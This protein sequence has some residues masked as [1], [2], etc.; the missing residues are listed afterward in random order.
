MESDDTDQ[1]VLEKALVA[2]NGLDFIAVKLAVIDRL[3]RDV[4]T[5]RD[6]LRRQVAKLKQQQQV[7]RAT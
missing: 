3:L 1:G 6:E 4:I 2:S 5:E 7:S